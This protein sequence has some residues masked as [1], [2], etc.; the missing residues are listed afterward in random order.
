M[1]RQ[2]RLDGL[3]GAT[4][5][6]GLAVQRL[7]LGH[8]FTTGLTQTEQGIGLALQRLP[9]GLLIEQGLLV[10]VLLAFAGQSQLQPLLQALLALLQLACLQQA[11]VVT[12][13]GAVDGEGGC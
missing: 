5:L 7:G 10:L 6:P 2:P 3:T 1:Q 11:V 4:Q 12:R 13:Q 9:T 8:L